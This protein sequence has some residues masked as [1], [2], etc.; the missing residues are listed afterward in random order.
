MRRK[1]L[2]AGAGQLGSRYLQGLS[3]LK[4]PTD[5]WVFD[6]SSESLARAKQRWD[7]MPQ[8]GAQQVH[9]I[10]NLS[11]IP[12]SIDLAIVATTADVR[13]E[14]LRRIIGVGAA[15]NYWVLEKV[16]AQS[17]DEIKK[18]QELL[19]NA[20]GAW[21]NTGMYM[22]PLYRNIRER[23]RVGVPISGS[24]KGFRGLA[25]NAI[26]YVDFVSRWNSAAVTQVDTSRLK[27]EWH[28]AKRTGFYDI[29]GDIHVRFSDGSE[30][31][32]ES[33]RVRLGYQVKLRIDQ[34]EWSVSEAEGKAQTTDGRVV[35]GETGL[36]SQLTAPL[37]QAIFSGQPCGLPTLAESGQQHT[38][39]LNAL[40][41]HW[42]EHM[43]NKLDRL[44]IT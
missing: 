28:P 17:E 36:Q 42:N 6:V 21:V 34:D 25:C 3:K 12:K 38:V 16:L 5:I 13:A 8:S 22:W 11:T 27:P 35:E 9:Y 44:P 30:L 40:L 4:E 1:L 24:F 19:V 39:F 29:D 20:K 14:L 26:H 10:D 2:I 37:V 32:L 23:Y 15:I 41:A 33:D 43:P 18:I 31:K 7:E